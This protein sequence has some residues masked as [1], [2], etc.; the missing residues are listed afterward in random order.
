MK[1]RRTACLFAALAF[2]MSLALGFHNGAM[3]G[4]SP[5]YDC[6]EPRSECDCCQVGYTKGAWTYDFDENLWV[7]NCLGCPIGQGQYHNPCNCPRICDGT[8]Q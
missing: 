1:Y 4:D 5:A 2:V 8:P 3:S 6:E 7:C